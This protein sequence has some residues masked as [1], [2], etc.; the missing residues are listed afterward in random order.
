MST[1]LI[2]TSIPE[3]VIAQVTA[4][5]NQ[6][7]TLLQPYMQSLSDEQKKRL[8][9]MGD[10]SLS[11]VSK[12]TDYCHSNP[13]FCPSYLDA[14]ELGNDFSVASELKPVFD[15]C[16]QICSNVDDTMALAGSE[17]Y[18]AGL[19]YYASVQLAA[20]TG[21]PSAKPVYDDLHQRFAGMGKKAKP[22]EAPAA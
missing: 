14:K 16:E 9:K 7:K 15:L 19:S 6:V 13:E 2:S 10:D 18:R 3:D 4:A 1:N 22:K 17:A 8:A 20:K 21:Q 11:F 12:V 5:L